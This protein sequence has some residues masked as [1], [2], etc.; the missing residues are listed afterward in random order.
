[1]KVSTVG[2]LIAQQ[3]SDWRDLMKSLPLPEAA[4]ALRKF[5]KRTAPFDSTICSFLL[6][7]IFSYLAPEIQSSLLTQ[8][9]D[10]EA[11]ELFS[12]LRPADRT[13]MLEELPGYAI[14]Q[15]IN[16]WGPKDRQETQQFLG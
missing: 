1:M 3:W 8:L 9:S 2:E 11:G 5:M 14:G 10:V 6:R 7:R 4:D 15:A 16:L 12:K 13:G